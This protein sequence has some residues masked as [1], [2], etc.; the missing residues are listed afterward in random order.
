MRKAEWRISPKIYEL[1]KAQVRNNVAEEV[2]KTILSLPAG[3]N[4]EKVMR[5]EIAIQKSIFQ[6]LG[7]L[8]KFQ[9]LPDRVWAY[10][11]MALFYP[12]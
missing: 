4:A 11:R 12:K 10:G 5:Y 1:K 3:D 9:S 7:A 6:N 8:K 2:N